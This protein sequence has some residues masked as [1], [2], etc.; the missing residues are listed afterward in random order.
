MTGKALDAQDSNLPLVTI[1]VCTFR[2]PILDRTLASLATQRLGPTHRG[3][4]VVADNDDEPSAR[5]RVEKARGAQTMP[6]HYIHAPARNISLARNALLD[7]ARAQGASYLAMIDDDEAA[8]PDW[9]Q[10]LIT[11]ITASGADAVLGPVLASYRP[12]AP[13]WLHQGRPHDVRP[14]IQRDGRILTGYAG[15]VILRLDSPLLR[16]RRFDLSFGQT[17]GEDDAFL[18]GLVRDGGRIGQAPAAIAHEEIPESR[19]TL[20]YLLRRSFRA[21]QTH[22]R[23]NSPIGL[24]ARGVMFAKAAAKVCVLAGSAGLSAFSPPRLARSLIRAALHAGVCSQL[25]GG[26]VLELYRS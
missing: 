19:E 24:A 1:G 22:G 20:R 23:I 6:L 21:G 9:A 25:A 7:Q 3:C 13:R 2:R 14:V 10:A 12:Q 18:R 8:S 11:E 16:D 4:I 26:K 15:N 5:S 17:G